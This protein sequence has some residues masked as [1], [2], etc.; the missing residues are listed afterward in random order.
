MYYL[1]DMC[2]ICLKNETDL[3]IFSKS[4]LE[5]VIFDKLIDRAPEFVSLIYLLIL[6]DFLLSFFYI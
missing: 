3:Q 6:H 1:L 2:F 5:N 4:Q